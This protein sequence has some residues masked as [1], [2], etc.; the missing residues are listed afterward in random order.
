MHS[1]RDACRRGFDGSVPRMSKETYIHS[2]ETYIYSNN[3]ERSLKR[4][5]YSFTQK[6]MHLEEVLM[7]TRHIRHKRP[8]FTQKRPIFTQKRPIF[9]QKE[10]HLEEV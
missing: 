10:M 8:T 5:V 2:K 9:T 7:A 1:E 6:G 4:N 3:E